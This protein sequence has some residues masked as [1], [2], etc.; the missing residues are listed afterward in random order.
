[1][2]CATVKYVWQMLAWIHGKVPEC[3][4]DGRCC[5]LAK[6]GV[7][8][9]VRTHHV[10][11]YVTETAWTYVGPW[12]ARG[13]T[14]SCSH[15]ADPAPQIPKMIHLV[16]ISLQITV[17]LLGNHVPAL[18][19]IPCALGLTLRMLSEF[20]PRSGAWEWVKRSLSMLQMDLGRP[21]GRSFELLGKTLASS[22]CKVLEM[23]NDARHHYL[24]TDSYLASLETLG[25]LEKQGPKLQ[26]ARNEHVFGWR[27][28]GTHPDRH[29]RRELCLVRVCSFLPE[30]SCW[31]LE[32]DNCD[33]HCNYR[34]RHAGTV[35]QHFKYMF[36]IHA[37]DR[38]SFCAPS[39]GF[40]C[41]GGL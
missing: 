15:L 13:P 3:D 12:P 18:T 39:H 40:E 36:R 21:C 24:V 14:S 35:T 38:T 5:D 4:M 41:A 2:L 20:T 34:S 28:A 25:N 32:H 26:P 30:E 19:M 22:L 9:C 11:P 31:C 17:F 8:A 1:M 27:W 10:Y 33:N 6:I 29:I 7:S 37:K 23:L 16:L